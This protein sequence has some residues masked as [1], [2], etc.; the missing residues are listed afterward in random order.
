MRLTGRRF[1]LLHLVLAWGGY[2]AA[3]ALATFGP[4][5]WALSRPGVHGDAQAS[6]GDGGI[7]LVVSAAGG[8]LWSGAAPLRTVALWIA[9]PPLVLW[10]LWLAAVSRPRGGV[11][12]PV[13]GASARRPAALGEPRPATPRP[14]PRDAAPPVAAPRR[15]DAR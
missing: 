8:T 12:V 3:L 9:G 11:T 14:A 15:D 7:R 2:W 13:G 1:R 5:L 4:A 6:L 10:L